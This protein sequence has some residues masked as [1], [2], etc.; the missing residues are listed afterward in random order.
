MGSAWLGSSVIE[1][2]AV[3]NNEL[4]SHGVVVAQ[5]V[6]AAAHVAEVQQDVLV[7][8]LVADRPKVRTRTVVSNQREKIILKEGVEILPCGKVF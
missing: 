5:H 7:L 8:I 4:V 2:A 1:V 3:S 6:F